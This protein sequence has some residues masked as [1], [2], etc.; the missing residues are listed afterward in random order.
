MIKLAQHN[1][2][3]QLSIFLEPL[4]KKYSAR[5]LKDSFSFTKALKNLNLNTG[6]LIMCSFDIVNLF[7]NIPL[8]ET[9]QICI[10]TLY[11]SHMKPPPLSKDAFYK[12][13]IVA[14]KAVKFSFG[15]TM[16]KQVRWRSDGLSARSGAGKTPLL[17][18]MKQSSSM[19]L[20]LKIYLNGTSDMLMILF[21]FSL[22]K[23]E[24]AP[25]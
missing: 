1:L 16:F 5:V 11:H 12:L 9:I 8:D 25:S 23:N 7:T 19:N 22:L 24:H 10:D 4:L 21:L 18:I 17:D 13:V 6:N 14:T 20:A 3:K 15:K 2:A